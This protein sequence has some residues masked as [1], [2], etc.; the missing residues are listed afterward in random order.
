MIW[1]K[2]RFIRALQTNPLLWPKKQKPKQKVS[3]VRC[4]CAFFNAFRIMSINDSARPNK[5][6][7]KTKIVN[8][9]PIE[10]RF[11]SLYSFR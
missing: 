2:C 1:L 4:L 9:F 5:Q 8:D 6:T 3:D 10:S 11:S 7:K